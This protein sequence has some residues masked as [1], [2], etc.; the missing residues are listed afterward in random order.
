MIWRYR[1]PKAGGTDAPGT[2]AIWLRMVN[3]PRS[4]NCASLNPSP[5]SVTRHTGK[6]E[7]SNCI[8]MGG[9]VPGGR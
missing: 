4:R 6:L 9:S 1:P 3:W 7:A 8:T 5:L 2:P